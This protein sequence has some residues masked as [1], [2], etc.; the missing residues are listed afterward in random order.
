MKRTNCIKRR[1][2]KEKHFQ[3]ERNEK[4]P[5]S[6]EIQAKTIYAQ[7]HMKRTQIQKNEKDFSKR[8]DGDGIKS[9]ENKLE[10]KNFVIKRNTTRIT[11]AEQQLLELL[12]YD[13]ELREIILPTLEETD[14]EPL[15]T[16]EVFRAMLALRELKSEING[17]NLLKMVEDDAAASDFVSVLLLS[18]PAREPDEA[19]DEVFS[20]G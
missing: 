11:V 10:V 2:Y 18:E 20:F 16:A 8:S 6:S 3:N 12:I 5:N 1:W 13:E 4:R 9:E 19:I 14:Y 15:A 7:S 17:E